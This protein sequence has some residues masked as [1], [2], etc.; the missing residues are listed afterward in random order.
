MKLRHLILALAL[1]LALPGQ[2]FAGSCP[3]LMTKID[4][5]L[6]TDPDRDAEVLAEIRAARE[7]GEKLHNEG[8]HEK[9]VEELQQ[10]LFLLGE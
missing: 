1:V 8:K 2:A 7:E 5:L 6:A 9:S 4:E 3:A 10:A